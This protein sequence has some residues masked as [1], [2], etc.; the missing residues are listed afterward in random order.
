MDLNY[1]IKKKTDAEIA[2][3]FNV[4]TDLIIKAR[5]SGA[6]TYQE[7]YNYI[8]KEEVRPR[9]IEDR[10]EFQQRQGVSGAI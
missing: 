1:P 10:M 8:K 3:Y 2:A 5:E 9:T 7:V 4:T 6:I